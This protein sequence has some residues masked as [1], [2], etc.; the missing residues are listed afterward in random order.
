M[1]DLKWK[2]IETAPSDVVIMLYMPDRGITNEERIEC[3]VFRNSKAGTQHAWA[4]HWMSLPKP[5]IEE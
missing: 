3:G 1:D 5:P 4:T 2:P